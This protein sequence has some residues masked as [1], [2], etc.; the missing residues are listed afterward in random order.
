MTPDTDPGPPLLAAFEDASEPAVRAALAA[1]FDY[2]RP[3]RGD[4]GLMCTC[5]ARG[6]SRNAWPCAETLT[7]AGVLGASS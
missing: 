2:H 1:V 3:I 4:W 6:G 5:W 7:I